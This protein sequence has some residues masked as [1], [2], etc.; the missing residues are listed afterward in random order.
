M[1]YHL[2]SHTS[3]Y[4]GRR[5]FNTKR[6]AMFAAQAWVLSRPDA[7]AT[8]SRAGQRGDIARYWTDNTGLQLI[9]Y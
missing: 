4:Y 1:T 9:E 3:A 6:K 8:I 7:S 5:S 2:H